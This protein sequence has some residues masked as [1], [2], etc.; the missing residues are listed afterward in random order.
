MSEVVGT[1]DL[2]PIAI[3]HDGSPSLNFRIELHV[4]FD[5]P[6]VIRARLWRKEFLRVQPTFPQDAG[7]PRYE[8]A[9][10]VILVEDTS[11]LDKKEFPS[12]WDRRKILDEIAQTINLKLGL[13]DSERLP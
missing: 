9:D 11:L 4:D 5:Q 1:F 12:S 10:E 6:A 3:S 7:C 2:E 13:S 8:P